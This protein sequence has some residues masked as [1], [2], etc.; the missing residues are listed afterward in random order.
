MGQHGEQAE[1]GLRV[2]AQLEISANGA[3]STIEP[4]VEHTQDAAGETIRTPVP[5]SITYNSQTYQVQLDRILADQGAVAISIPG[6][7]D[8]S[9]EKLVLDI[10]RKPLINLVWVGAVLIMIGSLVTFIR[11]REEM[12]ATTHDSKVETKA[13]VSQ[14]SRT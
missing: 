6:L 14:P 3:T 12:Y 8:R 4:A 13:P 1:G 7:I 11:R 9:P 2:A 5:A 10:S